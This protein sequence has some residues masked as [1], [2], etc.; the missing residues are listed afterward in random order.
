VC[1]VR[2]RSARGYYRKARQSIPSRLL[3]VIGLSIQFC[4]RGTQTLKLRHERAEAHLPFVFGQRLDN[5][6][7]PVV[8]SHKPYYNPNG[9]K[10]HYRTNETRYIILLPAMHAAAPARPGVIPCARPDDLP[11]S[12]CG[13]LAKGVTR[14]VS[15][16]ASC[17]GLTCVNSPYA[18]VHLSQE[19]YSA[20]INRNVPAQ[21][22]APPVS[23]GWFTPSATGTS[24]KSNGLT[25][26]RQ[27]TLT[28]YWFGSERRWWWV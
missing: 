10:G 14:H 12:A 5:K 11:V 20:G 4:D 27:A 9:V 15:L 8:V 1:A 28:P 25:P 21:R 19:T 16:L 24:G 3:T 6:S 22:E 2:P 23:F 7:D 18:V 26:S 17:G 13:E